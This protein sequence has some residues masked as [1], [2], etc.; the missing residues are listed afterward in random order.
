[1]LSMGCTAVYLAVFVWCD[2][3]VQ[4]LGCICPH[5]RRP[6]NRRLLA[7]APPR[8]APSVWTSSGLAADAPLLNLV[9]LSL[10]EINRSQKSLCV[11]SS[12]TFNYH[13][14]ITESPSRPGGQR[15]AYS[16]CEPFA[17]LPPA[18]SC[19]S[20]QLGSG[21]LPVLLS[22][23]HVRRRRREFFNTFLN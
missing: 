16:C 2:I 7:L 8:S 4:T 9:N 3:I 22:P 15:D 17:A 19:T 11:L 12:L 6:C 10:P 18:P 1:M 5:R 13:V 20:M 14:T 23:R 21:P